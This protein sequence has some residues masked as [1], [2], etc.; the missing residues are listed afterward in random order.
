MRAYA[1]LKAMPPEM[2][3]DTK[4]G[5]NPYFSSSNSNPKF[6]LGGFDE[7]M[8]VAEALDILGITTDTGNQLTKKVISKHHRKVMLNNHPDRGGSPYLAMKINQARE[9]LEKMSD[10]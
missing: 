4:T 6:Y 9:V 10:Q 3:Y 2:F 7:K 5:N 8:T 1:R